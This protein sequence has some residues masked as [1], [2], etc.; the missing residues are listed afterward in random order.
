MIKT[1]LIIS[2]AFTSTVFGGISK[3]K[4]KSLKLAWN[5]YLDDCLSEALE[6]IRLE[7]EDPNVCEEDKIFLLSSRIA[8]LPI[9]QHL[10]AEKRLLGE[11]IRKQL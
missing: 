5:Y 8:M 4:E 6:I 3:E 11:I 1:T 2:M 9:G 10:L 7:M